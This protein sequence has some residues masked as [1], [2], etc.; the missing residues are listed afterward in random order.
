MKKRFSDE[1]IINILKEA[2]AGLAVKELCRKYNISDATFYT[3]RK[4]FGGM[5]VSE[6]RRLKAVED[7]NAKLKKLLA[8]SLLDNEAL[9]AA[10]NRKLLT[11]ENKREA[12]RAMQEQTPISQRRACFLVG[13][14]RA[15]FHYRSTVAAGDSAL[16]ER[17]TELAHERRRFGYRRVH[18]LLR[19]EG[20]D[21]NHKKVYR[22]YREAGLA[23]PKRKRRKGIAMERHPLVLPEAPNQTWSM[24]FV[25]DSLACGRRIKCLTIVDDFTKEC[26]DIPVANGI[27]GN[28]VAR[29]LDTIAAFRGYPQA[30]RTDQGPEFTSKALDQWAYD[31]GVELKLIQPGKPTQNGFIESFNGRFRDECLNEH[32]FRDLA[33]ARE[34]IGNWRRDYNENRPHSALRYQTPLEFAAG[35]R[36]TEKGSKLTDVTK[37]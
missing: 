29:T 35:Y 12:V 22:L 3:W 26:L 6:A 19:R 2:E 13:L 21:V 9:K 20:I 18:Q 33:H 24:D 27:S 31:N 32:W 37:R 36:T 7:E 1:Q 16:S 25:M 34:I 11:V 8:E 30:V 4:K 23:V 15:S 5:E 14:S 17:I 28:Q 10:L